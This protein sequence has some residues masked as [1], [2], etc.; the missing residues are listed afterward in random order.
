M[1]TRAKKR[2]NGEGTI[3]Y[4]SSRSRYRGQYHDNN[5][6]RRSVSGRTYAETAKKLREALQLRDQ[7]LSPRKLKDVESLETFKDHWFQLSKQNWQFKTIE[8][9]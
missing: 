4:D 9:N 1:G 2:P 3:W 8:R 5:L 6:A 7:N